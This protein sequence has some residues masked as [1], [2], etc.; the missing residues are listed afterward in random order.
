MSSFSQSRY[1]AFFVSYFPL[2]NDSQFSLSGK[3]SVVFFY[4]F[5]VIGN[6]K[7]AFSTTFSAKFGADSE[8]EVE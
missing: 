6:S 2:F 7:F 8:A 1:N 3:I 5:S 4:S